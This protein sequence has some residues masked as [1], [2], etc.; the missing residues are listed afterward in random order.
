[1]SPA[2]GA[3][4]VR[5]IDG[6]TIEVDG[7]VH[8]IWGVDAPEAGQKC[9]RA[10]GSEWACGKA[11]IK[12]MD[13]LVLGHEVTCDDRGPD[14]YGRTLSVC[15]ADG[16]DVGRAMVTAGL[17]WAFRKYAHDYDA[18]E[19]EAHGRGVGIWQAE[20]ETAWE[21]RQHRWDGAVQA[22]PGGCPIK[23]NVNADGVRIYHAPWSPWYGRTSVDPAHG[24]R[25]FCSEG[26][27]L[28][29]GWRAPYWGGK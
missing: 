8:R 13:G 27:A 7:V 11:A 26:D 9:R 16:L 20:T 6:D 23:G 17:A 15:M 28:K 4:A 12:A 1:M 24:E 5:V 3:A 22:V 19:D 25:W 21:Y 29:A 10:S 18:A 14:A 2:A